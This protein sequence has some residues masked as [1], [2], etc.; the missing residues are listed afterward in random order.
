MEDSQVNE[1]FKVPAHVLCVEV[2]I[3]FLATLHPVEADQSDVGRAHEVLPQHF[4]TVIWVW[5]C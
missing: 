1:F 3:W 5:S 4:D 2:G